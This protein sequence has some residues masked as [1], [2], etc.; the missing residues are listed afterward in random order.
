MWKGNQAGACMIS[1]GITGTARQGTMP[2]RARKVLVNTLTLTAP[3]A[4]RIALRAR[5]ICGASMLSPAIFNA[6]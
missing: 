3:P 2:N 6:K 1:T 4:S 5:T